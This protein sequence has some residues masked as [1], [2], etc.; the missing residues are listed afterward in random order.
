MKPRHIRVRPQYR[1]QPDIPKL[2]TVLIAVA[3]QKR[4]AERDKKPQARRD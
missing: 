3:R 1:D 4:D 2:L